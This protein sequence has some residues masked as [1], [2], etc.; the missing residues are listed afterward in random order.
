MK[1]VTIYDVAREAGVSLAT[2]SRVINGSNVVREKTKQ[3]VLDV[4]D[5]LDF[6]PNDIA[7]GLATS[8]TTTIAIVFPQ[9]LFAHVKDMI[10][11]IGDTGRHLDYNINMYTTDDIGDENTVADVTERLVKSR[12]DGVIL[13][14]NDNIDETVESI[15]KYNLPIVVIGTKMSGENIGSIYIDVKK[16]AEE[17]VDKYLAKGKDDIVYILPKQNLIKSD[18]IIEGIKDTY[19]KYNKEFTTDQIV[20]SSSHYEN[21]YPNFVEYFTTN[22]ILTSSS[23]YENTYPN[24]VEYFKNHKHDLVFCGYDKDGVAVINAAQENGIKIPEEM[25]V[26]GMLNTSY[27][28]M[29]KPTLSSM[30]VPVYDMGALAVRLLTKF[31]QDEEITS[32]E[33]AVQHMFI[34]RNSTND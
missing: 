17:I 24:F 6:K 13:F 32:K 1:K 31:L 29:C 27:S 33:I 12:V 2:V 5:R 8:K 4:I 3:K 25:E 22:Q 21:T 23:H 26:V 34:K 7:R 11:G 10:G 15:V 18:E 20:T 28:I 9:S 19:K 16:A 30:N 14:N